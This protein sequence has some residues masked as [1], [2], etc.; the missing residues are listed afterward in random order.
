MASVSTAAVLDRNEML[1]IGKHCEEASCNQ[2]DFLPFKCGYCRHTFCSEHWK[3]SQHDCLEEKLAD[4]RIIVPTCPLCSTPVP[5]KQG[6]DPNVYMDRHLSTSCPNLNP[7]TGLATSIPKGKPPNAC[8]APRC[9]TKVIE[10]IT[11][12]KCSQKFCAKHRM[13][14]DHHCSPSSSKTS[15]PSKSNEI[16]SLSGL[17]TLHRAKEAAKSVTSSSIHR[18]PSLPADGSSNMLP[19]I[20]SDDEPVSSS[21]KP[22]LSLGLS[23][24]DRRA[25]QE[26]QSALKALEIRAQKGILTDSQKVEYA[27]LKALSHRKSDN[28]SKDCNIS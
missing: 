21:S 11:C 4:V 10:P 7:S 28:S 27:T 13:P 24:T 5:V 17:A 8:R 14:E 19:I 16:S 1:D 22:K 9:Q 25:R 3:P 6:E 20:I 26:N 2:I 15:A 12:S 18:T 23:Q